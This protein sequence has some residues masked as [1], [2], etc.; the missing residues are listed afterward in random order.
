M[1]N[2]RIGAGFRGLRWL[3]GRA[4]RCTG[5]SD[6]HR[7]RASVGRHLTSAV[8]RGEIE[9]HPEVVDDPTETALPIADFDPVPRADLTQAR[10]HAE[11]VC[12]LEPWVMYFNT[13]DAFLTQHNRSRRSRRPRRR[14]RQFPR[15]RRRPP[16]G[17]ATA[18]VS[19]VAAGLYLFLS[20]Y[21]PRLKDVHALRTHQ[22][23]ASGRAVELALTARRSH[24]IASRHA[25]AFQRA[26]TRPKRAHGRQDIRSGSACSLSRRAPIRLRGTE[27]RRLQS[28]C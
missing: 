4:T 23:R 28:V 17:S 20:V 1:K 7:F 9:R 27:A 16:V 8:V 14:L 15:P 26:S 5:A 25:K 12:R 13:A 11:T 24:R 3:R 21:R 22:T 6:A 18:S 2:P 10:P 19:D